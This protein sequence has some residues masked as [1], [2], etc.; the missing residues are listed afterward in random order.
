M[1]NNDKLLIINQDS[2]KTLNK[3]SNQ[4]FIDYPNDLSA[5]LLSIN[6]NNLILSATPSNTYFDMPED[7][8]TYVIEGK[9]YQTYFFLSSKNLEEIHF[10]QNEYST[11]FL[12]IKLSKLDTM[13][14]IDFFNIGNNF[15]E[16]FDLR[17]K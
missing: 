17:L 7:F 10:V 15:S 9:S 2:V 11:I 14:M 1:D 13:K 3:Y 4:I 5:M 6:F 12:D 16:I 8:E